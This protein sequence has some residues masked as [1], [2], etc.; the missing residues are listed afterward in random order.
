MTSDV[1]Q[2]RSKFEKREKLRNESR[3]ECFLASKTLLQIPGTHVSSTPKDLIHHIS[4]SYF[5]NALDSWEIPLD[6]S[7][8]LSCDSTIICLG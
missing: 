6:A 5:G 1:H 8:L 3:Y 2:G 4:S 7:I